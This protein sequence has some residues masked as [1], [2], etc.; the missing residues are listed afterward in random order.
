MPSSARTAEVA[1][2]A[3]TTS[4]RNDLRRRASSVAPSPSTCSASDA[5][6]ARRE[7]PARAAAQQRRLQG[8]VLDDAAQIRLARLG[9][10]EAQHIRTVWRQAIQAR[11]PC[12]RSPRCG[13]IQL[14]PGTDCVQQRRLP[15]EMADTRRP[16]GAP[17]AGGATGA[18]S[19]THDARG[20]DARALR[21]QQ[22]QRRAH[23]A[24]ADDGDIG[25]R[26]SS[27]AAPDQR[28][29]ARQARVRAP[30]PRL[31]RLSARLA[32]GSR[33]NSSSPASRAAP[34]SRVRTREGSHQRIGE[35]APRHR[36]RARGRPR[37]APARQ[38][39][40]GSAGPIGCQLQQLGQ[41]GRIT[42]PEVEALPRHRMQRL[43]GIAQQHDARRH[44]P[45][46][47]YSASG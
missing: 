3:P 21:Q 42:Q 5:D 31:T 38:Q 47:A 41:L 16:M 46:C 1:P 17:A 20:I 40:P 2:S 22:C 29:A 23:H 6:R 18:G 9:G 4:S 26:S 37:S 45:R 27:R 19:I 34:A 33:S 8:A 43:R 13:G 11:P 25:R 7:C 15:G 30:K 14:R 24:A 35:A 10:I 28:Q 32:G 12:A 39:L 36:D 44:R